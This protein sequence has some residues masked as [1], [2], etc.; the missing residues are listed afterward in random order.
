MNFLESSYSKALNLSFKALNP[1]K[2]RL[3]N[4][5]CKV[6]IFI[7]EQA[8]KI[9]QREGLYNEY[10]FFKSFFS[11][12]NNGCVWADQDFKSN[13]H[14]YHPHKKR[15]IYGGKN[16]L[17]LAELYYNHALRLWAMGRYNKSLFYLGAC[18]HIIQDMTIPQHASIRLL[19]Q[20][21]KY[22]AYVKRTYLYISDFKATQKSIRL[23]CVKAYIEFNTKIALKLDEKYSNIDNDD[24]RFY[25]TAR[26]GL[27]VS[28]RTSAGCML[29][30][31][32]EVFTKK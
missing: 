20:H 18:I 32:D 8:L 12:L 11:S 5:H 16:A 23:D 6:H 30:F 3:I 13:G 2:K 31:F 22:E 7:N 1:I 15:G 10:E 26:C 19:N 14:F 25:K 29:M 4:T 9:L 24:E 17:S 21:S 27:P 28:Q